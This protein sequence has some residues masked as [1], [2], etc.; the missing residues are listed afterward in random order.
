MEWA[1]LVIGEEEGGD[2][3]PDGIGIDGIIGAG[4]DDDGDNTVCLNACRYDVCDGLN[5]LFPWCSGGSASDPR[6][7][8]LFEESGGLGNVLEEDAMVGV[9]EE[10]M[11]DLDG[12]SA[13]NGV[14]GSDLVLLLFP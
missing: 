11:S 7:V 8:E 13:G 6:L 2:D 3:N 5:E 14:C 12:V 4:V 10:I 9:L 1:C